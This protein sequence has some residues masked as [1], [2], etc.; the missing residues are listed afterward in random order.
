MSHLRATSDPQIYKKGPTFGISGIH[1]D[2]IDVLRMR[3]VGKEAIAPTLVE[4]ETYRSSE[5]ELKGIDKK[6]DE[7]VVVEDA[8][9][10]ADESRVPPCS[11]LLK[12]VSAD[13]KG[14]GIGPDG[15]CSCLRFFQ[16]RTEFNLNGNPQRMG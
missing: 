4:C 9:E 2:G 10:F 6:R 16:T 13:P 15:H 12:N 5:A 1:V 11:Q 7:A 8:V 3:E 14:F